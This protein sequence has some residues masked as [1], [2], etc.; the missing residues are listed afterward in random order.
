MRPP[1]SEMRLPLGESRPLF[2]FAGLPEAESLAAGAAADAAIEFR[3]RIRIVE[4]ACAAIGIGRDSVGGRLLRMIAKVVAFGA[5][6]RTVRE[7][8]ED[9]DV[10]CSSVQ[11]AH[12]I[13]NLVRDG[14]LI[15]TA[16]PG[17]QVRRRGRPPLI[18]T[19]RVNW[20]E[21]HRVARVAAEY[22]A[23]QREAARCPISWVDSM[24]S[25]VAS[26]PVLEP[27]NM[28]L[29]AD[30]GVGSD[31]LRYEQDA[32]KTPARCEQE[33]DKTPARCEQDLG[34]YTVLPPSSQNPNNPDPPS[35][36]PAAKSGGEAGEDQRFDRRR[37]GVAHAA[38]RITTREATVATVLEIVRAMRCRPVGDVQTLWRVAAAH[39][40]GLLSQHDV[41]S[42]CRGVASATGP[43]D[44]PVGYFR[45][46]LQRSLGLDEGEMCSLLSRVTMRG[47]YPSD[48]PQEPPRA[49]TGHPGA[50]G[51]IAIKRPPAAGPGVNERTTEEARQRA[52]AMLRAI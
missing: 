3:H 46:T 15:H 7:F 29:S 47:R 38:T 24:P 26:G 31:L 11:M 44:D 48:L 19:L 13:E 2:D 12:E 45:S 28:T 52:M 27:Q 37:G 20:R 17:P 40:A 41:A 16:E 35:T 21:C 50:C 22:E 5:M 25:P 6:R 32:S 1:A 8:A 14:L 30:R 34:H 4:E 43:I 18:H 42:A 36:T 49:S 23:R 9:E 51:G 39:D 10:Q 33:P